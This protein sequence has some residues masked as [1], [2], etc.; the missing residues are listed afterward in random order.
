MKSVRLLVCWTAA[1]LCFWMSASSASADVSTDAGVGVIT[2]SPL[3][4][5]SSVSSSTDTYRIVAYQL[6]DGTGTRVIAAHLHGPSGIV[7][8]RNFVADSFILRAEYV[9]GLWYVSL[10]T[11]LQGLGVID[12]VLVTRQTP[13]GTFAGSDSFYQ[14][15]SPTSRLSSGRGNFSG[16]INGAE[17]TG[18]HGQVWGYDVHGSYWNLP[19]HTW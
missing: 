15:L 19:V 11:D 2:G 13:T 8:L 18:W 14:F 5:A 17:V 16:T 1:V 10:E 4:L 6:E 9:N 12:I 3:L 7:P